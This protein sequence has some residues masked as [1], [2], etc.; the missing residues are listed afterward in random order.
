M[1][2]VFTCIK[3]KMYKVTTFRWLLKN[4][5]YL[6]MTLIF[7]CTFIMWDCVQNV[8]GMSGRIVRMH[9]LASSLTGETRE[10]MQLGCVMLLWLVTH[11]L[12]A[13]CAGLHIVIT[14][15]E[16]GL[17]PTSSA[18]ANGMCIARWHHAS[19]LTQRS[20]GDICD[21]SYHHATSKHTCGRRIDGFCNHIS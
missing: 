6:A 11:A 8:G 13:T 10:P 7:G 1:F 21:M 4:Y 17:H 5:R 2:L 18:P 12:E 9:T 19:T 3:V 20:N 16:L 14:S 15:V